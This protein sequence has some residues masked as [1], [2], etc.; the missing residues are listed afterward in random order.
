MSD[1][2]ETLEAFM[3]DPTPENHE[4]L[5]EAMKA[6]E[7]V[8]AFMALQ[9]YERAAA[10]FAPMHSAHE[11]YA[12]LKEEVEEMWD[13]IKANNQHRTRAE[14]IQVAAMGIRFL[15]DVCKVGDV[16]KESEERRLAEL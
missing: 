9:E 14:A 10:R 16:Y 2:S 4:A 11:G 13:E 1:L 8:A 6:P 3:N 7:V 5:S 15:V 12:V